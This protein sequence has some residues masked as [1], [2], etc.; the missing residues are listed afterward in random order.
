M[1]LRL[2]EQT[3]K[4]LQERLNRVDLYWTVE[5]AAEAK[6]LIQEYEARHEDEG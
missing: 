6:R 5:Q 2:T 1:K 3:A 4:E